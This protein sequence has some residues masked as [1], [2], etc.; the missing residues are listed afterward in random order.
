[1]RNLWEGD[2]MA[3]DNT[4]RTFSGP[5]AA[6]TANEIRSDQTNLIRLDLI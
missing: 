6:S 5:A 1:M 2:Q 3:E 4:S